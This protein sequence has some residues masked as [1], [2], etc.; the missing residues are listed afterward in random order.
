MLRITRSSNWTYVS[1]TSVGLGAGFF[2]ADFG[3]ITLRDPTGKN[4]M[5]RY[6]S[7]GGGLNV[8]D[9]MNY[10]LSAAPGFLPGGSGKIF[11]LDTFQGSDLSFSDIVGACL[12]L[13]ASAGLFIGWSGNI[14]LLGAE[15]DFLMGFVGLVDPGLE[16]METVI[17]SYQMLSSAKAVLLT[18]GFDIGLQADLGVDGLAGVLA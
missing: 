15:P 4:R 6:G 3:A 2:A 16:A 17:L 18:E 12:L 1:S 11:L 5:F 14:I 7:A 8:V 10:S 13:D 9:L